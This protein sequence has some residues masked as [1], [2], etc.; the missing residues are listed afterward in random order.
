L[1]LI[2]GEYNRDGISRIIHFDIDYTS[3]VP[4][5]NVNGVATASRAV[6]H[7]IKKIQGAVTINNRYFLT[8]SGGNLITFSWKTGR[9]KVHRNVF[10]G[11]PQ[12]LSYEPKVGLWTLMEAPGKRHV[13]AIDYSKF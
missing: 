9:Q 7:D 11:V 1:Q 2:T 10:P 3:K 13:V 12:D 5:A 8:Q 4:F 6:L